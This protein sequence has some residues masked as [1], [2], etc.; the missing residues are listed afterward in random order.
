MVSAQPVT[1]HTR[2][3]G[4][5]ESLSSAS[6]VAFSVHSNQV[7]A[8]L[9]VCPAHQLRL[10]AIQ[11][12]PRIHFLLQRFFLTSWFFSSVCATC[13]TQHRNQ[14]SW[15]VCLSWGGM[16]CTVFLSFSSHLHEEYA[17]CARTV[18]V[19]CVS[20]VP[21]AGITVLISQEVYSTALACGCNLHVHRT[22]SGA[23]S[24]SQFRWVAMSRGC[25]PP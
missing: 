14:M 11:G 5:P 1:V 4:V 20:Q 8:A 23:S 19:A 12:H 10:C 7:G 2:N 6:C 22:P 3:L 17:S 21:D 15:E 16:S 24:C 9:C 25:S 18:A 13:A